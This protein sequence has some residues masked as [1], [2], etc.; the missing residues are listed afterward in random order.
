MLLI[1]LVVPTLLGF[2]PVGPALGQQPYIYPT[3]GQNQEQRLYHGV[4]RL[5]IT[6]G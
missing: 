6:T 5:P 2:T 3:Q 4:G 1:R